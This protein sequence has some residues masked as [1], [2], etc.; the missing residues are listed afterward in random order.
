MTDTPALRRLLDLPGIDDLELKA[1]M[2]P[3]LA[4][5]DELYDFPEIAEAI[6]EAARAAFG[7]TPDEAA[8]V[9]L[10]TDWDPIERLDPADRAEA[11]AAEGWDVL[12]ARRKPLRMLGWWTL[13]LALAMRGVAGALPFHAEPDRPVTDWGSNLKAEATRFRKR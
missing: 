4:D 12:D 9:P 8:A 6:D 10:P 2:K 1:L 11:F 13:P 3:R 5:P 7:L